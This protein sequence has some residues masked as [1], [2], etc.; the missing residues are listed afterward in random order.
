MLGAREATRGAVLPGEG[1]EDGLPQ[2]VRHRQDRIIARVG[3]IEWMPVCMYG[4]SIVKPCG[5][6]NP[7][8]SSSCITAKNRRNERLSSGSQAYSHELVHE[9]VLHNNI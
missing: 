2:P 5:K 1:V 7:E 8:L 9:L 3:A 6:D 4:G